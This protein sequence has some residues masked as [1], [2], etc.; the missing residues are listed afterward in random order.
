M[1]FKNGTPASRALIPRDT[2][3][4]PT[5]TSGRKRAS[6]ARSSSTYRINVGRSKIG[7]PRLI[8]RKNASEGILNIGSIGM[9]N[10]PR[11][12]AYRGSVARR[13]STPARATCFANVT[14]LTTCA[15]VAA[16][17]TN[18]ILPG[19]PISLVRRR[20]PGI[21]ATPGHRCPGSCFLSYPR[22]DIRGR[23][24]TTAVAYPRTCGANPPTK[25]KEP[26]EGSFQK[27]KEVP[28]V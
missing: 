25:K 23:P 7:V 15:K 22:T 19:A 21:P 13:V 5:T 24:D 16:S 3:K 12:L 4:S 14:N 26:I 17:Q 1:R 10:V 20:R 8:A 28:A 18:R 11:M 2:L 9:G 27:E 6:S